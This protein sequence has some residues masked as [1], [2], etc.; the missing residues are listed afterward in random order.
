MIKAIY[1][2]KGKAKEYCDLAVNIYRGCG[3]GCSYCYAPG[4]LHIDRQE[5][6]DSAT[7]R[8]GLIDVLT[9][10]APKYNGKEIFLCFSCDPYAPIDEELQITRQAI[11]ILKENNMTVRILTKGG[12]RATRDFDL[13]EKGRD[14]FGTTMTFWSEEKSRTWE[15]FAA[16][17]KERYD[18]LKI[19]KLKG[20]KTWVSLEPVIY[21]DQTLEIIYKTHE[22]VD[23]YRI[24]KWNYDK[25]AKTINWKD[26]LH[27]AIGLLK[28]YGK[29]YKIKEDL[30]IYLK[31]NHNIK[32][33]R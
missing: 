6:T 30:K 11:R 17:P 19:A 14:W 20:F 5:F 12:W 33:N 22:F 10:E 25:R 15:P 27:Q 28:S 21:P 26:F 23:E 18:V 1:E 24:G 29:E 9:K 32:Y 4:I 3:H 7:A 13:L 31:H 2:P 16:T 8:N